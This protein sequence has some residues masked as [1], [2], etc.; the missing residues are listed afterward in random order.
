M[1]TV[2]DTMNGN[3]VVDLDGTPAEDAFPRVL[4][5]DIDP[6]VEFAGKIY[7]TMHLREPTFQEVR[8][9]E[10]DLIRDATG[11]NT[12]AS[13]RAYALTLISKISGVPRGAIDQMR[14]SQANEAFYFL[15]SF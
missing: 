7:D 8:L 6:P 12:E 11:R 1:Q 2:L 13:S 9:A 3:N 10:G 5:I 4:D 15:T 14:I